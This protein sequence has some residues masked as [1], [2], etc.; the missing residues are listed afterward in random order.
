MPRAFLVKKSNVSPGKRNWSELPDHERGDVYIPGECS[1]LSLK[2]QLPL[3]FWP[4]KSTFNHFCV[5]FVAF[6]LVFEVIC[7]Y[8]EL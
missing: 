7:C 3:D 2:T 5:L 8:V 4:D 1:L 6:V